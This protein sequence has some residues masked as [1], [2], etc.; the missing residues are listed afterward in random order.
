MKLLDDY[1]RSFLTLIGLLFLS[2][3]LIVV[4]PV[5]WF[6]GHAKAD[7]L[8]QTRGVDMPWYEAVWINVNTLDATATVKG[9]RK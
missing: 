6:E 4:V 3:L 8:K 9:G 2:V 1:D 5:T 7:W